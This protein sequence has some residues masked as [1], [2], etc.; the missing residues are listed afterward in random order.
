MKKFM[1]EISEFDQA[2]NILKTFIQHAGS[3]E[4]AIALIST[5]IEGEL[6][7]FTAR[8]IPG[9]IAYGNREA[10][11]FVDEIEEPFS[12]YVDIICGVPKLVWG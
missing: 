11:I 3:V 8:N 10:L 5:Q 2:R 9:Y 12:L 7:E 6:N 4:S 1:T